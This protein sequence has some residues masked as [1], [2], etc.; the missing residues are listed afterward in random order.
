[1]CVTYPSSLNRP[2]NDGARQKCLR[3]FFYKFSSN[4]WMDGMTDSEL[5]LHGP[6]SYPSNPTPGCLTIFRSL[7]FKNQILL[8]LRTYPC[9]DERFQWKKKLN[10][11]EGSPWTE[12][13]KALNFAHQSRTRPVPL[14]WLQL[15]A[16]APTTQAIPVRSFIYRAP[17]CLKPGLSPPGVQRSTNWAMGRPFSPIHFSKIKCTLSYII[18]DPESKNDNHVWQKYRIKS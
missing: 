12:P 10:L 1:M 3:A 2:L 16:A 18:W 14:N 17:E 5:T 9:L 15:A 7:T 6:K 4:V 13:I 11:G 8:K